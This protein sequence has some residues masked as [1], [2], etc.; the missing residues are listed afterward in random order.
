MDA[1]NGKLKSGKIG[2]IRL[3]KFPEN[4]DWGFKLI[5]EGPQEKKEI[6]YEKY[7]F[8]AS[9]VLSHLYVRFFV[10]G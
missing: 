4:V 2:I 10:Q 9:T 3:P 7:F 1:G 5:Y 6:K 8:V